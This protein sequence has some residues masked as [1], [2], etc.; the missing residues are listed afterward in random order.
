LALRNIQITGS[1]SLLLNAVFVAAPKDRV[2]ELRAVPYVA[3]VVPFRRYRLF[4]NTAT[5]LVNVPRA[6]NR[7]GGFANA[8]RGVKIGIL[9]S[10]IDDTH[11]ASQDPSLEMPP[12][13][14]PLQASRLRVHQQ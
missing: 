3:A 5:E 1:V 9:D 13:Y 8:G 14:P 10:G 2:E 11:P 12:G 6:W 4:K 7:V